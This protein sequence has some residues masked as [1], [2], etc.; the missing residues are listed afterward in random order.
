MS[1]MINAEGHVHY[2]PRVGSADTPPCVIN[3][4]SLELLNTRIV[5]FDPQYGTFRAQTA[6]QCDTA[7]GVFRW[8]IYVDHNDDGSWLR[9][10]SQERPD[11][12]QII[13]DTLTFSIEDDE[14][15]A[16]PEWMNS[17]IRDEVRRAVNDYAT[18]QKTPSASSGRTASEWCARTPLRWTRR[19]GLLTGL[20]L[21]LLLLEIVRHALLPMG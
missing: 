17:L 10:V 8:H 11:G 21:V 18:K 19:I 16:L 3:A 14:E 9:A 7:A 4:S 6:F 2:V 13:E 1:V 15:N 5:K 20:A 12:A